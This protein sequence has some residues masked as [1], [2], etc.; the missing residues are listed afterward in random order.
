MARCTRWTTHAKAEDPEFVAYIEAAIAPFSQALQAS[1]VE[2]G[3][4]SRHDLG[5]VPGTNSG[6]HRAHSFRHFQA[7]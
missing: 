6:N 1:V 7:A 3:R 4:P 2:L 5:I